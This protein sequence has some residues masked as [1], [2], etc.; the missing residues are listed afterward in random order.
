MP[1]PTRLPD[2]LRIFAASAFLTAALCLLYRIYLEMG[3]REWALYGPHRISILDATNILLS[4]MLLPSLRRQN[5][6]LPLT[7][8]LLNLPLLA[9]NVFRYSSTRHP[10]AYTPGFLDSVHGENTGWCY[11]V[12]ILSRWGADP[13]RLRQLGRVR[14]WEC[15]GRRAAWEVSGKVSVGAAVVG[16]VG[17]GA[18]VWIERRGRRMEGRK[19]EV[20]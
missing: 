7:L 14:G 15:F 2:L 1:R 9:W 12:Y 10:L 8:A 5:T 11:E 3:L 17:F 19:R 18:A 4:V 20:D 6:A 13:A 16:L